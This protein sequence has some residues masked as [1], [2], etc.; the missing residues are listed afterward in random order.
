MPNLKHVRF[1][2][3]IPNLGAE[4]TAIWLHVFYLHVRSSAE[5]K[6]RG[7][8]L[9]LS[10]GHQSVEKE[11]IKG[12]KMMNENDSSVTKCN[13]MM[14]NKNCKTTARFRVVN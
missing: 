11:I 10:D 4:F 5:H 14:N 8:R 9:S 1:L 7:N 12:R 13:N 2:D 3:V 6:S